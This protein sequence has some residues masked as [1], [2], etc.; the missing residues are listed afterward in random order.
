MSSAY[1][2]HTAELKETGPFYHKLAH[3]YVAKYGRKLDWK[4]DLKDGQLVADDVN[5]KEDVDKLPIEEALQ[6]AEYFKILRNKIGVWFNAQYGGAVERKKKKVSFKALFDKP[7]LD[8]PA[9][10]KPRTIHYYSRRFYHTRV[11]S[12]VT[13]RW[14]ASKLLEKPPKEI[15][16]RNA[17]TKE[18]WEGETAEFKAEV[19]ESLDAEHK[20]AVEAYAVATSGEAPTNAEEYNIALNNAAYYLQPFADAAHERYGMNVSIL[21]CGPIPDRGGRIEMRSVHAGMTNG[22]V[23]RVWSDVDRAGFDAAQ[24]SFVQFSHQCFTEADC[25]ARSLNGMAMAEA[26]EGHV[27]SAPGSTSTTP[28]DTATPAAAVNPPDTTTTTTPPPTPDMALPV[29]TPAEMAAAPP[30]ASADFE[31]RALGQDLLDQLDAQNQ[32]RGGERIAPFDEQQLVLFDEDLLRDPFWEEGSADESV[33]GQGRAPKIGRALAR[34][35]AQLEEG[36]RVVQMARLEGMTAEAVERVNDDARNRL[37]FARIDRGVKASE[38][39]EMSSGSEDE[40]DEVQKKR[41]GAR[42]R[43]RPTWVGHPNGVGG[44]PQDTVLK[45]ATPASAPVQDAAPAPDATLHAGPVAAAPAPDATG[46]AA[47]LAPDATLQA[48]RVESEI[49]MLTPD[50][51]DPRNEGGP[52]WWEAQNQEKWTL[53]LV[54]AFNGLA[55]GRIWGGKEWEKCVALLLELEKMG[56]FTDKGPVKAPAGKER[57]DEIEEFMKLAR[58]WGAPFPLK[59][60]I[61]PKEEPGSF[62]DRWWRWW[63]C[64]QPAA[65][66]ENQRE[67][68]APAE[69]DGSEWD[70]MRKRHGRNGVLMYVGG[71]LW[72]GEAAVADEEQGKELLADWHLAVDD[73]CRVLEE[74]VKPVGPS[75]PAAK[76]LAGKSGAKK[77]AVLKPAAADARTPRKRKTPDSSSAV[78]K[79]NEQP[80]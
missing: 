15:T 28:S 13:A 7:E 43:P 80:E 74:V 21:L 79:E 11:K 40:G 31:D 69:L 32:Q 12:R 53:E 71:L 27:D 35:M 4:D 66:G 76:T 52:G 16:V 61:G 58:R 17:V 1:S 6:R 49:V 64:S 48:G 65:R 23:P 41:A 39:L 5:P 59:T 22:L 60:Q 73:V 2:P 10:A 9:P 38:A 70:E 62:A 24:R 67:W 34:E 46:P 51:A 8:P 14:A 56:G 29:T 47:A 19:Q 77:S 63:E 33:W 54:K 72:W 37:L 36:H 75:R 18:C 57:P 50:A 30:Q 78:E 44:A 45:D 68:R 20:V 42:P 25:K 55:R 26:E 3:L